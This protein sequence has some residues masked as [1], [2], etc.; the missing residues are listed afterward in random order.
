MIRLVFGLLLA[1]IGFAA[2]AQTTPPPGRDGLLWSDGRL[3]LL[4]NG[5]TRPV[6]REVRLPNGTRVRPNGHVLL[7]YGRQGQLLAG[8]GVDL[9][10]GTWFVRR[11]TNPDGTTFLPLPVRLEK[12]A[13]AAATGNS[14]TVRRYHYEQK[15]QRDQHGRRLPDEEEDDDDDD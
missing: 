10:T 2:S 4:Q 14:T 15:R 13:K 5:T 1:L 8:D 3:L 11:A 9:R 6:T 12:P 7:A